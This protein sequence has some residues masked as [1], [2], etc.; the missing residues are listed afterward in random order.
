[1]KT[2]IRWFS[3]VR[4][5]GLCLV[6]TYH[7][8]HDWLPGGFFGVDIFFTLSGYLTMALA[9]EEFQRKDGFDL[10]A[11]CKRRF[12]RIA[13]PLLLCVLFTL[14]L[15][16]FISADFTA[17]IGR[18]LAGTLG[19]VSNYFEIITGGSYEANILPH[20]YLHTWSLSVEMHF[21]LIWGLVCA[22]MALLCRKK[23]ER[24]RR[25]MLAVSLLAGLGSYIAM[26]LAYTPGADSSAAYFSSLSHAFPFFIGAAAAALAGIRLGPG[27]R[28]AA[29]L[30]C[31]RLIFSGALALSVLGIA[32]MALLL[33]FED[34]FVYRGGFLLASLLACAAILCARV[35]HE[36][37]P[38]RVRE[39][40]AVSALADLSYNIYLYHWPLYIVFSA[41]IHNNL[42]ASLAALGGSLAFSVFV[43]YGV[44]PLMIKPK[45]KKGKA[46]KARAVTAAS[47]A[48]LGAAVGAFVVATAPAL[49][50]IEQKLYFGNLVQDTDALTARRAWVDAVNEA[51]LRFGG[52]IRPMTALKEDEAPP[53]RP[54]V[55]PALS[56]IEVGGGVTILGDSIC[57]DARSMLIKTIPNSAVD[58]KS[59]RSLVE[60]YRIM[61][62]MQKSGALRKTV[63]V[64]LGTNNEAGWADYVQKMIDELPLGYRLVFVTPFDG[65]TP[66][67]GGAY[68]TAV[69]LRE[70]PEKYDF[71]TVADWNAAINQKVSLLGSDKVHLGDPASREIYVATI[72]DAV[73]RAS[74]GPPKS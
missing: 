24:F 60:G 9:V 3:L 21:Y 58:A 11:F 71:V 45:G 2:R 73:R 65:R 48:L 59:S 26:Q 33:H 57:V 51:P 7:F 15:T 67:H 46:L 19:F 31:A 22:G 70:L 18:Q 47:L 27:L 64:A 8:F 35:L 62:E 55:V 5:L 43:F 17:G 6:L 69:R 50:S 39:P 12:L 54:V 14:P 49:T 72:A 63:V 30:K 25:G 4:I 13:P 41:L 23:P 1:M 16:L 66:K 40:R 32:A 34:A 37:V 42:W 38:E 68:N 29:E 53:P 10:A 74:N 52:E 28:R 44:E 36:T 20:L 56:Q 61:A